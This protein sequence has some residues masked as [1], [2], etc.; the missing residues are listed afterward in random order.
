MIP[1]S[2]GHHQPE[3]RLEERGLGY[4]SEHVFR[5]INDEYA[6]EAQEAAREAM[7]ETPEAHQ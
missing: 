5:P 3:V 4:A 6:P 1:G 2:S 7:G